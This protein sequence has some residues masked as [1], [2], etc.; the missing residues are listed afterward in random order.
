M[1]SPDPRLIASMTSAVTA[2]PDDPVLRLHL[3]EL[4]VDSGDL[5]TAIPHIA[6]ALQQDPA[7]ERAQQLMARAL[8]PGSPPATATTPNPPT[9]TPGPSATPPPPADSSPPPAPRPES[10]TPRPSRERDWSA[11][12]NDDHG[13]MHPDDYEFTSSRVTLANVAGMQTLTSSP[14]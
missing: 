4:L 6:T 2:S 10:S 13:P 1:P 9:T 8:N 14:S 12:S 3:G 11:P 7:S 5:Q